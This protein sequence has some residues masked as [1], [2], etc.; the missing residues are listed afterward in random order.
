VSTSITKFEK[1]DNTR[2]VKSITFAATDNRAKLIDIASGVLTLVS[3]GTPGP[4]APGDFAYEI[5]DPFGADGIAVDAQNRPMKNNPGWTYELSFGDFTKDTVATSTFRESVMSVSASELFAYSSCRDLNVTLK[6]GDAVYA[7]HVKV[8]D[9]TRVQVIALPIG[10]IAMHSQCG[11]DIT[12]DQSS[13][14]INTEA[15]SKLVELA[16]SIKDKDKA[17][18]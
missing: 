6:K 1:I 4:T 15:I 17:K 13:G 11:Y 12:N 8:A 9:P 14:N 5:I 2:I 3:A 18:N 16:K 7:S 10:Q